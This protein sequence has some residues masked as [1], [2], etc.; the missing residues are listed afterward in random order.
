MLC[1]SEHQA[2]NR[3]R[4]NHRGMELFEITPVM[5]GGD[6]LSPNNKI[7]LTRQ[8][9]IEAVRYWKRVVRELRREKT[10]TDIK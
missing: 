7:W 3:D 5:L 9:H 1:M 2:G 4:S 10:A 8:Q 6:P